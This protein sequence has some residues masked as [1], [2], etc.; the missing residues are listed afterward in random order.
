M[1]K[2]FLKGEFPSPPPPLQPSGSS[3]SG[4]GDRP[5]SAY[6]APQEMPT[7]REGWGSSAMGTPHATHRAAGLSAPKCQV[8]K[9][10]ESRLTL[11]VLS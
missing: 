6:Q 2:T 3:S 9:D 1:F 5:L 10:A 7:T 8:W 4:R 11:W